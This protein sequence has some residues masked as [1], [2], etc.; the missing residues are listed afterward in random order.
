[1]NIYCALL[2]VIIEETMASSAVDAQ[3]LV[4]YDDNQTPLKRFLARE[5]SVNI[6][7]FSIN[8]KQNW[9]ENGVAGVLWDSAIVLSE[10]LVAHPDLVRGRQIL[11]LGAG[12]GLPSIVAAKLSAEKV[13]TTDQP[14][15]IP[16]L[17]ENLIANLQEEE[18]SA[19]TIVPLDWTALPKEPLSADVILGADLVYNEELF[20]ALQKVI[21]QIITPDNLM[22]MASKIRYPKDEHFFDTLRENF[23]VTKISYDDATDVVLFKILRIKKEL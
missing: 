4:L 21:M 13:L 11:E 17:K 18:M 3:A 15:A 16:L 1:M 2:L 14:S 22:L 10:Y 23:D 12:I 19:I 9:N 8:L 5:K 20:D 7:S 6:G